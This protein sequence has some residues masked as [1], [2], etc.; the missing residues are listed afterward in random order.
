MATYGQQGLSGLL[1]EKANAF[2]GGQRREPWEPVSK[3]HV[4]KRRTEGSV[5]SKGDLAKVNEGE[6]DSERWGGKTG[7]LGKKPAGPSKK[8]ASKGPKST[9][10]R[11]GKPATK[12]G[13]RSKG[14]SGTARSLKAHV[15]PPKGKGG[16]YVQRRGKPGEKTKNRPAGLTAQTPLIQR[17]GGGKNNAPISRH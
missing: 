7:L 15:A 17:V 2:G 4:F 12:R 9:P 3:S 1:K 8:N 11:R 14:G 16:E 6:I 10:R 13:T 5:P